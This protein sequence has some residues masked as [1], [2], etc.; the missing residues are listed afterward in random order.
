SR[1]GTPIGP[2][3]SQPPVQSMLI[4]HQND[5]QTPGAYA[6]GYISGLRRRSNHQTRCEI[7]NMTSS[8]R[9]TTFTVFQFMNWRDKFEPRL[10][11]RA[12]LVATMILQPGIVIGLGK[13][14]RGMT[15]R[16]NADRGDRHI[17]LPRLHGLENLRDC[18]E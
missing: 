6:S 3:A 11:F 10:S 17:G 12:A 5:S 16:R 9:P 18:F 15:F 2:F 13:I 4:V 14:H 1:A 7:R 8:T